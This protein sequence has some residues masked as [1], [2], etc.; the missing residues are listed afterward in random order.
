VGDA[1]KRLKTCILYA[2]KLWG[3]PFGVAFGNTIR[4]NPEGN[5][6]PNPT[7]LEYCLPYLHRDIKRLRKNHGLKVIMPLGN[8]AKSCFL[9]NKLGITADRQ[10]IYTITNKAFGTFIVKP[11]LHPS[12]IMRHGAFNPKGWDKY[13]IDDIIESLNRI[14]L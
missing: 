5:R 10:N 14:Y 6:I 2:K 7:E 4:D 1:G 12:Y 8:A 3:K 11:S 13:L 9:D